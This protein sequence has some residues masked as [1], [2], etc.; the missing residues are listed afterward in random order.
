[1]TIPRLILISCLILLPGCGPQVPNETALPNVIVV[2]DPDSKP[3]SVIIK[4]LLRPDGGR[5]SCISRDRGSSWVHVD[6][7]LNHPIT[8]NMS[9][10]WCAA[11]RSMTPF[12]AKIR[13]AHAYSD[14]IE[15]PL[16]DGDL[17]IYE[18]VEAK[19]I[20]PGSCK[21]PV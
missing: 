9:G 20:T 12:D 6:A 8:R 4:G 19:E 18:I 3:E 13:K 10:Y 17:P 14:S 16:E 1:M 15:H 7:S 5:S 11:I 21:K 2:A